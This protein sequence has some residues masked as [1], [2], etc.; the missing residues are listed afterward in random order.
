MLDNRVF[1]LHVAMF[2]VI[3][4]IYG[5]HICPILDSKYFF[6]VIAPCIITLLA[7]SVGR[8]YLMKKLDGLA[9]D[10]NLRLSFWCD[11]SLFLVA[12]VL[13]SLFN[14]LYFLVPTENI[15]KVAVS[16]LALGYYIALDLSLRREHRMAQR[17]I[18][19][20]A[21][22]PKTGKSMPVTQKFIIFSIV[23][24]CMLATVCLLVVYKDLLYIGRVGITDTLLLLI[25]AETTFVLLVLGGYT[26]NAIKQYSKNLK[27]SLETEHN[28]LI[29][30][31]DGNLQNRAAVTSSDEFG[32]V[33]ILTNHMIEK[34]ESSIENLT[35]TQNAFTVSLVS[36][37]TKRD[38]ET[39]M[40]LR[41]TQMYITDLAKT[42]RKC[43]SY[44]ERISNQ[45]I[46]LIYQAAPLHDIGKVGIPDAILQKQ[47]KLDDAEYEVMK[48]HTI[49]G[50]AAL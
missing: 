20:E 1:A 22:F 8:S 13:V 11:F 44:R 12:G 39:G 34:L 27:L 38:N 36:L 46:E 15:L 49:I 19:G 47:G 2:S 14:G 31:S 33:A 5:Q 23:N 30:V 10:T 35:K 41:R 6:A 28:A 26:I 25:L 16:F 37:A 24:L 29:A 48:T 45:Y 42:L 18:S 7:L 32:E 9:T 3:Y 21:E 17:I 43:P 40:H 4:T 50:A